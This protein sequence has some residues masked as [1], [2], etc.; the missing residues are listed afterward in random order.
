MVCLMAPCVRLMTRLMVSCCVWAYVA[1][2]G[3]PLY[4]RTQ[5]ASLRQ[6][7]ES[8]VDY[9][10]LPLPQSLALPLLFPFSLPLPFFVQVLCRLCT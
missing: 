1:L 9:S 3:T 2:F 8:P 6:Q 10:N 4:M 7:V 5:L